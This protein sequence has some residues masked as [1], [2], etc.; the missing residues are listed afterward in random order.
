MVTSLILILPTTMDKLPNKSPKQ[1]AEDMLQNGCKKNPHKLS[2]FTFQDRDIFDNLNAVV[3]VPVLTVLTVPLPVNTKLTVKSTFAHL[4][5][6]FRSSS[7]C[8]F[9]KATGRPQNQHGIFAILCLQFHL[10][11]NDNL[12]F[13]CPIE[14]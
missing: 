9:Y 8:T 14:F 5:M 7:C 3:P 12:F 2:I 4:Q 1:M 11:R 10:F 6:L 13:D